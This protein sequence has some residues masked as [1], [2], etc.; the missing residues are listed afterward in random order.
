MDAAPARLNPALIRQERSRVAAVVHFFVHML[1]DYAVSDHRA[2]HYD[3]C[4]DG[5]GRMVY[6]SVSGHRFTGID[7]GFVDGIGPH[8]NGC[9]I[10]RVGGHSAHAFEAAV[11]AV[12]RHRSWSWKVL[13]LKLDPASGGCSGLGVQY[14]LYCLCLRGLY[15]AWAGKDYIPGEG[16][17][18]FGVRIH[19]CVRRR[20]RCVCIGR[21]VRRA[22]GSAGAGDAAHTVGQRE[23]AGGSCEGNASRRASCRC[24]PPRGPAAYTGRCRRALAKPFF[25]HLLRLG[26]P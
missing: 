11:Y 20:S 13:V 7:R 15:H 14:F 10:V 19:N 8:G 9:F 22:G 21:L 2:V 26:R 5:T 16:T 4:C 17:P 18:I 6:H 24:A 3:R 25:S 1:C 12:A 23:V